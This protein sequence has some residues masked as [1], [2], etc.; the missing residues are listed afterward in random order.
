MIVIRV[1]ARRPNFFKPQKSESSQK[2]FAMA[3]FDKAL[4]P[5]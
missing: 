1:N 3:H 5:L 2:Q 4:M